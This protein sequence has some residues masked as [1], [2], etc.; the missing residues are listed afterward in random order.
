[1]KLSEYLF[2]KEKKPT[3]FARDIGV[4]PS[5]VLRWI[6]GDRKPDLEMMGR[7]ISA[8]SGDVGVADFVAIP[9]RP[10]TGEAA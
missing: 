5:T 3:A 6:S 4:E 9:E 7:I 1:M 8:T 10:I 2:A